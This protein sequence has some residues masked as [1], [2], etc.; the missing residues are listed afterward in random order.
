MSDRIIKFNKHEMMLLRLSVRN[1]AATTK[2]FVG[3]HSEIADEFEAL[4]NLLARL[5]TRVQLDPLVHQEMRTM[6]PKTPLP[7]DYLPSR[8]TFRMLPE[9]WEFAVHAANCHEK[10]KA[11]ISELVDALED[12]GT[13]PYIDLKHRA[14]EATHDT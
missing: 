6:K 9:D 11:I 2:K 7:W 5:G 8:G 1:Q 14:W 13:K 10:Y 4:K 12:C 3:F